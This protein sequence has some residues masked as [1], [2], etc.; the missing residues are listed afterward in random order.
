MDRKHIA[1]GC[2][3][4]AVR[5]ISRAVS[6]TYR[7]HLNSA[8]GLERTGRQNLGRAK[9]HEYLTNWVVYQRLF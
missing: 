9:T 3:P 7:P 8:N 2:V 4:S 6:W 1:Y 5:D